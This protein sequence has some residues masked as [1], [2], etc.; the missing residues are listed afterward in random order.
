VPG[1]ELTPLVSEALHLTKSVEEAIVARAK[2]WGSLDGLQGDTDEAIPDSTLVDWCGRACQLLMPTA[3]I[4][5]NW[6][7]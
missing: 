4:P 6:T 1:A 3:L 2:T 5:V 7:G